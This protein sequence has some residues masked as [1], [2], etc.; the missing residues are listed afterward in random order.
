METAQVN[1]VSQLAV[2]VASLIHIMIF[3]MESVLFSRAQIHRG[4]FGVASGDLP[5]V[6]PWAFNQGFYN[7]FLAVGGLAGLIAVQAGSP[8][9]GR[10]LVVLSAGSMLGA[11]A[12]LLATNRKM[13]RAA[14]IQGLAPLVALVFLLF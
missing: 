11:A 10:A 8:D 2:L 3:V 5:A 4:T 6:R 14:A 12:V 9:A 7:L 1:I 13:L